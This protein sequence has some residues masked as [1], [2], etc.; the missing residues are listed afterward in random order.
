MTFNLFLTIFSLNT[1]THT[2][3][4]NSE[5]VQ[6][7]LSKVHGEVDL[8]VLYTPGQWRTLPPSLGSIR[9]ILGPVILLTVPGAAVV[10]QLTADHFSRR[11][12][13]TSSRSC[14]TTKKF[15]SWNIFAARC[16]CRYVSALRQVEIRRRQHL[17]IN[18]HC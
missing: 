15:R 3:T 6:G 4:V 17:C 10:A 1:H 13:I 14:Q 12:I 7:Y 2:H 5:R 8:V 11:L 16:R 18:I 9:G